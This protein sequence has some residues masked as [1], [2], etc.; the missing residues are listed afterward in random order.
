LPKFLV[1]GLIGR[2]LCRVTAGRSGISK[3]T[4]TR[5]A[6]MLDPFGNHTKF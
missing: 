2:Y 5:I 4:N 6:R 1:N 3:G